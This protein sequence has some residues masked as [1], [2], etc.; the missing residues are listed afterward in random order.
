MAK[1]TEIYTKEKVKRLTRQELTALVLKW[2]RILAAKHRGGAFD[3]GEA[4]AFQAVLDEKR[5]RQ[6]FHKEIRYVISLLINVAAIAIIIAVVIRP[7]LRIYG[8]SMSGTLERGDIVLSVKSHHIQQ[9]DLIAVSSQ[10]SIV[11]RRVIGLSGDWITMDDDGDSLYVNN[12]ELQE[13]PGPGPDRSSVDIELP[14]QVQ[15]GRYFVLADNPA[16]YEDSRTQ[17][18]GDVSEGQILGKVIFRIWPFDRLGP[19][20]QEAE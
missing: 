10:G 18:F 1:E 3:A 19:V 9:G 20:R 8:D 4:Q 11:I 17:S 7:V 14:H 6:R 15:G 2:N 5:Y 16:G 13:Y 12:K